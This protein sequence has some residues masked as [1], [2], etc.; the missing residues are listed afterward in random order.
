MVY[1]KK[2]KVKFKT[3]SGKIVSFVSS[4][5][6][7]KVKNIVK[8]SRIKISIKDFGNKGKGRKGKY[9]YVKEVNKKPKYYKYKEGIEKKDILEYYKRGI[10]SKR[11]GVSKERIKKEKKLDRVAKKYPKIEDIIESGYSEYTIKDAKKLTPTNIRNAYMFLLMNKDKVGDGKG[12][13]RD[14]EL[15][16]IITR[17]ENIEKWKHRVL[18]EIQL[19]NENGDRL[20]TISNT[21]IKTLGEIKREVLDKISIGQEYE[22]QYKRFGELMEGKGY[23]ITSGSIRKGK[24][25]DVKIKLIFRKK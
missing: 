4:G 15:L 11:G 5:K 14:K 2:K 24:I 19:S 8:R 9:Y 23:R 16:D 25:K 22:S 6:K 7:K 21:Q 17:S 12:I 18:F 13:V 10:T 3:K 1:K 20:L